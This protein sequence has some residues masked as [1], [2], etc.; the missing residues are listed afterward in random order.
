M[1]FADLALSPG[2]TWAQRRG[3]HQILVEPGSPTQNAC[4]ESF[5]GT[6]RDEYLDEDWFELLEQARQAIAK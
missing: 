6:F 1:P 2:A 5:N 4:I 3:I